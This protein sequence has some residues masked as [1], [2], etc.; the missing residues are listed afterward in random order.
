M[1]LEKGNDTTEGDDTFVSVRP[2]YDWPKVVDRPFRL[3]IL[4]WDGT[5]V[6][7]RHADASAVRQR[8]EYLLNLGVRIAVVT[9]TN[10]GNIN[11]QLCSGMHGLCMTQL[12]ICT[13]R[14]SESFGF[15][16]DSTPV[17]L[18]RHVATPEEDAL[19]TGAAEAVRD[20]LIARTGLQ[21]DVV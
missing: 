9:G 19:L 2:N 11:K 7:N 18:H 13:N 1:A 4:D 15:I 17:L 5:A 6:E 3:L 21:A 12:F 8:F 10:F 16:E 14:G 20:E